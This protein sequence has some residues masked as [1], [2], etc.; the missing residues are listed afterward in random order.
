M[1]AEINLHRRE[2]IVEIVAVDAAGRERAGWIVAPGSSAEIACQEDPKWPIRVQF[3]G[4]GFFLFSQVNLAETG[5]GD[6]RHSIPL[7]LG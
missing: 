5:T 6:S 7:F 2:D 4:I 3:H 1:E